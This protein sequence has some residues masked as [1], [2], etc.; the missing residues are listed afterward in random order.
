MK[1]KKEEKLWKENPKGK[2]IS[3]TDVLF[4]IFDN[5]ANA[6]GNFGSYKPYRISAG[7]FYR[8]KNCEQSDIRQQLYYLKKKRLIKNVIKNNENYFEITREGFKCITWK[9]ITDVRRNEKWDKSFRLVMFDVPEDKKNTRDVIRE[10]LEKIGFIQIQKSVFMY[11]FDC[12]QQ[13]DAL[14][15]LCNAKQYIK[16]MVVKITGGEEEIIE[17]FLRRETLSLSDLS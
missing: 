10:Q 13:I 3:A 5:V 2:R 15:Y 8:L 12:K 7:E 6:V 9:A 1:D 16:Y 11:P 17:E 4:S 14:C